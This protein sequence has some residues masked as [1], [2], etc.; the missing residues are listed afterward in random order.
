M[1]PNFIRINH[2]QLEIQGARGENVLDLK[3]KKNGMNKKA[4]MKTVVGA[5]ALGRH[6][7]L[8]G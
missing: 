6:T 4:N 8:C 2:I 3:G 1:E 7:R 5:T